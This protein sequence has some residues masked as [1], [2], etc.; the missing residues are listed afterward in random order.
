MSSIILAS[1]SPRRKQLLEQAELTFEIKTAHANEDF[2]KDMESDLVPG[3]IAGNKAVAVLESLKENLTDE[4]IVIAA[5]TVVILNGEI[6][7][8]PSDRADAIHI[9]KKLSGKVHKVVTGVVLQSSGRKESFSDTTYVHFLPL[10]D[11]QIE[12]YVDKYQPMDKAGA[13]AIQEWIG[14][15]GIEKID[16]DFYNVMGLPV[17]KVLAALKRFG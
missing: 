8:K 3:F 10:T 17:N 13:Y 16:G 1:Q 11:A 2:P 9:L 14:L 15:I 12:H 7:G 4:T 5:D 6:I